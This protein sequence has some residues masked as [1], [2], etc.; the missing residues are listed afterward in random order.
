M[1]PEPENIVL[2]QCLK[3]HNN[4]NMSTFQIKICKIKLSRLYIGI[5][6]HCTRL[7]SCVDD[8][9]FVQSVSS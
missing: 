6:V 4:D 7:L 1:Q 8:F 5:Y 3:V 2:C 9:K